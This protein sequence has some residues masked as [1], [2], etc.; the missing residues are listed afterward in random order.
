VKPSIG[1]PQV[2]VTANLQP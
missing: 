2:T 1:Q